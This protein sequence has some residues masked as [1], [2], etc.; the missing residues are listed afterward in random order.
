MT[1]GSESPVVLIEFS[2]NDLTFETVLW[3]KCALYGRRKLHFLC[4]LRRINSSEGLFD[5]R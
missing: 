3:L 5:F 4:I 2:V 1:Y